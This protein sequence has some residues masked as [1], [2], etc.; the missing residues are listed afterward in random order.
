MQTSSLTSPA[1]AA[2]HWACTAVQFNDEDR[3]EGGE[4]P[5]TVQH[6]DAALL[7]TIIASNTTLMRIDTLEYIL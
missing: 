7:T 6:E 4:P 5:G 3:S 2:R 1:Q